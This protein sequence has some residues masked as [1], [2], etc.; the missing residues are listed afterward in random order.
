MAKE[1]IF[2]CG[3]RG[4]VG[5]A[6]IRVLENDSSL[7]ILTKTRKELNLI[8]QKEVE[9]FFL[10]ERPTQVYLA[11]AKV[12]GI[13]ANDNF[14]GEFLYENLMIQTNVINQAFNSGVKK[15]LFLGS[16]C[17]YPK[18]CNQPITEEE[19]LSGYLEPTNDAYAVAKIAGIKLCEAYNKQYTLTHGIDYRSVMPSNL[20]GI[21]DTY[22]LNNSHVIPAL[23]MKFQYAVKNNAENVEVWGTGSPKREFMYVDDLANAC[24]FIMNLSKKK[25]Y[26]QLKSGTSHINVGTNS[27]ISIYDLAYLIR[28]IS[29]FKGKIIFNKS[30]PD[31]TPK[32]LMDSKRLNKLGW[33]PKT[34]LED[35]LK[36]VYQNYLTNYN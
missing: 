28:E 20:Y 15:L 13:K 19:L 4:M 18:F 35:G 34:I 17:I 8:N 9:N 2:I 33:K 30:K 1:R 6:L 12:G 22:D 26:K 36:F 31:G 21:G 23:I 7:E 16:S 5:S 10:R 14:S 11:A 24:V 32:K 3:H 27:D 29:G 25:F